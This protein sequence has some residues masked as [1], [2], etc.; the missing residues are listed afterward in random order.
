MFNHVLQPSALFPAA[1]WP[2]IS[3]VTVSP[4]TLSL[5]T[6]QTW[7]FEAYLNSAADPAVTWSVSVGAGAVDANGIYTA[8]STGGTANVRATLTG[9]PTKYAEA[10][11]TLNLAG[12]VALSP[13]SATKYVGEAQQFAATLDGSPTEDV[14]WSVFAGGGTVSR[15]GWFTT[16]SA[17]GWATVRATWMN[18]VAVYADA[19]V[20]VVA[21]ETDI[22]VV[23]GG[24]IQI[25]FRYS[26][27]QLLSS[28]PEDA[29]VVDI[30]A[31]GYVS[32]PREFVGGVLTVRPVGVGTAT[33]EVSYVDPED[34]PTTVTH[35]ITVVPQ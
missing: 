18:N 24:L 2:K 34:G 31:P 21:P 4:T 26:N 5:D 22:T 15:Q 12:V 11:I 10:V 29:A 6:G 14:V 32:A 13:A 33:L 1:F 27:G 17:A 20:T 19:V 3:S 25:T 30:S 28:D 7:P 8:P 9:E 23:S 35:T 16:P